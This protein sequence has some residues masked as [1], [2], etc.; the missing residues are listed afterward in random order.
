[1]PPA[2][3][4]VIVTLAAFLSTRGALDASQVFLVTWLAN[5]GGAMLVYGLARRLGPA[6][7][8]SRVAQ[9]LIAPG[10]VVAVERN[11]LRFGLLGLFAARLLPG[12]RSF[13]APFAGLVGLSLPRTILPIALASLIWY[14]GL[15]A[16]GARL[17]ASWEQVLELLGRLNTTLGILAGALALGL[18][19]WTVRGLLRRR[20]ARRRRRMEASLAPYPSIEARAR[21]DPAAAAVAAF[22]LELTLREPGALTDEDLEALESQL[23]ARFHLPGPEP[24]RIPATE[25]RALAA[26]LTERLAPAEREGLAQQL[27]GLAF[28]EAVGEHHARVMERAAQLLGLPAPEPGS[29]GAPADPASP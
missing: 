28:G 18:L 2:P 11:Y 26:R 5:V 21:E 13:T 17:G 4:D 6:F 14:G 10:A 27:R 23:G 3:A 24:P 15:V 7:M 19:L 8:R 12:F 9:Q 1:M 20:A 16:L 22:L 29:A 25:A